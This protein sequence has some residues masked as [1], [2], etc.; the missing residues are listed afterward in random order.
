MGIDEIKLLKPADVAD[1]LHVKV[2]TLAMWR[3]QGKGPKWVKLNRQ[4]L[5]TSAAIEEF[6]RSLPE[7]GGQPA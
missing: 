6:I 5:Y 3:V 2:G 1:R 7:S 4:V